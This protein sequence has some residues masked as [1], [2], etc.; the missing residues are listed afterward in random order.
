MLEIVD[1]LNNF[2]VKFRSRNVQ[3]KSSSPAKPAK[4]CPTK[5]DDDAARS[6]A[7]RLSMALPMSVIDDAKVLK[8]VTNRPYLL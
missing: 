1:L 5:V 4:D 6:T 3:T 2:D 7:V 8:L